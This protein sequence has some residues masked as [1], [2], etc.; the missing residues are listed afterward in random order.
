MCVYKPEVN[1]IFFFFFE[2]GTQQ[3]ES[4][5][6]ENS[7]ALSVSLSQALGL[8]MRHDTKD[9]FS[10]CISALTET[11]HTDQAGLELTVAHL[12]LPLIWLS[13]WMQGI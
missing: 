4:G 7:R 11:Y 13:T 1:L 6:P 10:L 9:R 3:F 2:T 12:L 8:G 5:Q